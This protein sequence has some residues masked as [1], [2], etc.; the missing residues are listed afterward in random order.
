MNQKPIFQRIKKVKL[1]KHGKQKQPNF[2]VT[3]LKHS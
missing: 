2:M 1:I 3:K